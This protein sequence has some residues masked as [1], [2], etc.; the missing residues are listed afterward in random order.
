[1]IQSKFARNVAIV[2]SG[3]AAAQAIT[4]AFS[5]VITRLYDPEAFGL[6]GV[7]MALV[8][9]LTPV[10]ALTYPIAIVLPKDDR[11]AKGLA[12]L[13]FFIAMMVAMAIAVMFLTSGE[14]LMELLGS[15]A[16]APYVMLIPLSMLFVACTE[17]A[18]QWL[19]RK[20]LFS[21][22]ARVAVIQALLINS[23]KSGVGLFHPVGAVLVVVA[24]FGSAFHAMLLWAGIR[25]SKTMPKK[26]GENNTSLSE[27]A[28]RHRDFPLYRAPQVTI[29]ALS[30]SLPILMLASFFGPAAAGF[31]T[32]S[33]TV[34]G[35]PSALIGKSVGDVFYPRITEAA[36]NKEN[37]FRLIL[38][39]T[40][41][42]A[43]V[44]SIPFLLVIAFGPWLF[45]FVFG[46]EWVTAG[47]YAQ[48][49][50]LWFF[51]GFI[52]KPSVAA[53]P[54]LNMQPW[55]LLYELVSTGSKVVALLIGFVYWNDDLLA[56][57]LMCVF[58]VV[59]YLVLILAVLK[60]SY[61][62]GRR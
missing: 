34:M 47:E 26:D 8:S 15:E 18:Q 21:I 58:G 37:L 36:H 4:L 61:L 1:M 14:L 28:R 31:Y 16:I 30:Q 60:K 55:L 43:A 54:S 27:L 6:Y 2:A 20:K 56:I 42:L 33:K 5:P 45:S 48:W 32:L 24:A 41:A 17:I 40:L 35:V 59:A 52:N 29:N 62:V 57:A 9:I 11:D 51:F 12:K 25:K 49:L 22:T 39:A 38:R 46:G 44:G 10:A 19:I 7:F 50:A 23:T 3:T 13:S 53:M